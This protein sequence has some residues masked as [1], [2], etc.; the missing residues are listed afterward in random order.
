MS[1]TPCF[2]VEKF[3]NHTNKYELQHPIVWN[4][5][6]TKQEFADLFPYTYN[7]SYDLFSI[8]EEKG[9]DFPS[10]NGIHIGLPDDV[11]EDIRKEFDTCCY[12]IDSSNGPRHIEPKVRWFTYADMYIYC[13]EHPKVKDYEGIEEAYYYAEEGE[14]INENAITKPTPMKILKDR[15]DA[16]LEVMD[17]HNWR[18]NYSQIRIVY[19]ID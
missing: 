15:V 14:K 16:F 17:C 13:L 1:R 18:N 9:N 6:H 10:M 8:V 12:D 3:D 4:W 5:D 19:W 11:S 2:Y 7:G